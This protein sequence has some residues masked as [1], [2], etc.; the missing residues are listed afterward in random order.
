MSTQF[1]DI[2]ESAFN[3]STIQRDTRKFGFSSVQLSGEPAIYHPGDVVNLPYT[4][5]QS[6]TMGAYASAWTVA[7]RALAGDQTALAGLD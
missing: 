3:Y 7:M 4:S 5:G 2:V 1:G 6:S